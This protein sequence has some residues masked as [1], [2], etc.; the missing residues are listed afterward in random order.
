VRRGLL[1]VLLATTVGVGA[2][3][4]FAS[5]SFPPSN[6]PLPLAGEGAVSL[7]PNPAGLEPFTRPATRAAVASASR[8]GRVSEAADLRASDRAW[9]P[10]VRRMWRAG[11]S[12]KGV[13]N[14]A[15]E[16]S[17]ALR[18]S[19]YAAI[20]RFSCGRSLVSLSL[21]VVI[22]PR[23]TN[24]DACR[25]QLWFVDRRGHALLYYVY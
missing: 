6:Y 2:A 17:E 23:D 25:S 13:D 20:A 24:C 11:R 3:T 7:C 21:Q 14:Q 12:A 22:G 15:V 10:Q 9:W 18:Q 19:A 16:G 5:G 1:A 4:A 8:Y